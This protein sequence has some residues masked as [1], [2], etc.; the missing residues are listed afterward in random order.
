M[1]NGILNVYKEKGY[2]SHD[3]VAK[4]RGIIKQKKI[5]HTGTLDPDAEGV[6][7]VCI[8][9]ATK[10]CDMLT[11]KDKSYEAVLLLGIST[12]TQDI[13]GTIS[14]ESKV[15]S[16]KDEIIHTINSFVGEYK[17]I[18]PMYSALKVN[19]RKLYELARE[20][21]VIE[22]KPRSVFIH[23]IEILHIDEDI[24]EVRM[25]VTCSKGT[26]IRTLCND[27]G[28]ILGC[29]GC[30]KSLIRT[31]VSRFELKDSLKLSE[32]EELH[33]ENKLTPF[34]IQIEDMFSNFDKVVV[35]KEFDKLI[36]NGNKFHLV[37][38]LDEKEA[39]NKIDQIESNR[40]NRYKVKVYDSTDKFMGIYEYIKEE[41]CFKP[42]KMFIS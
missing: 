38:L 26:Y 20:G 7:P 30:M 23:N 42:V 16:T 9:K 2:T 31:K 11:D 32:I 33:N 15:S 5:G 1:I 24:N 27:I 13:T 3:V 41:S 36:Y 17:Q 8:G 28:E 18:P 4:L 35:A 22:R 19:G 39:S 10:L 29:G 34:I 40:E 37:N 6:L 21:K 25:I 12:D 14:Q